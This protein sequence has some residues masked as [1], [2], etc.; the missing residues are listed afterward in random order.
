MECSTHKGKIYIIPLK[1]DF[2]LSS[3]SLVYKDI[4]AYFEI[5]DSNSDGQAS[6]KE[7]NK[8][9]KIIRYIFY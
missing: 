3:N 6:Y 4:D 8:G 2:L 9:L 5:I 1:N 7:V